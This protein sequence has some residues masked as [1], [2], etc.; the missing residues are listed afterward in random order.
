MSPARLPNRRLQKE[1][2]I[3]AARE[4]VWNA[5][6]TNEGAVTFFAPQANVRIELGG[7]YE[8]LFELD[9]PPGQQGTEGVRVLSYIPERMLSFE[10]NAP[11]EFRDLRNQR[12]WVVIFLDDHG[13]NETVV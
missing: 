8:L 9:A 3:S 2:V 12:T 1:V 10:W 6:A 13:A 11:V 4:D 7:P 5:F